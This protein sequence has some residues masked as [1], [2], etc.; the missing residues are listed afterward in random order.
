[1]IKQWRCEI[2]DEKFYIT[3]NIYADTLGEICRALGEYYTVSGA[4]RCTICF[5]RGAVNKKDEA[6]NVNGVGVV[7]DECYFDL[8]ECGDNAE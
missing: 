7:C 6:H 5:I 1:M 4:H 3:G 8:C 2:S